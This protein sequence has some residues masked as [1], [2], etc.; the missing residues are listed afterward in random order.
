MGKYGIYTMTDTQI[1]DEVFLKSDLKISQFRYQAEQIFEDAFDESSN[2]MSLVGKRIRSY[3]E[4]HIE[5]CA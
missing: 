2:D 3:M 1:Y 5:S 4:K